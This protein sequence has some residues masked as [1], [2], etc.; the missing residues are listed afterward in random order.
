[1]KNVFLTFFL[2]LFTIAATAQFNGFP[3]LGKAGPLVSGTAKAPRFVTPMTQNLTDT[4]KLDEMNMLFAWTPAIP[5]S[6][7][8]AVTFSYDLHI[9]E[10]MPGQQPDEGIRRNPAVYKKNGIATSSCLIPRN[11]TMGR[12]RE[13]QVYAIQVRAIPSSNGVKV[14]FNGYSPYLL[15]CKVKREK[16]KED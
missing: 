1:M 9:V 4:L 13:G 8:G 11:I 10:L 6:V 12:I 2:L 3:P 5:E 15:F 16:S 7:N 14:E